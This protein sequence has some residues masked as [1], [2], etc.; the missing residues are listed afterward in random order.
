MVSL[1][2]KTLTAPVRLPRAPMAVQPSP[3]APDSGANDEDT[4]RRH[5]PKKNLSGYTRSGGKQGLLSSTS[6]TTPKFNQHSG[7]EGTTVYTKDGDRVVIGEPEGEIL[8][9]RV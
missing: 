1:D 6:H 4:R 5:P 3:S 2:G 7:P 9:V 8:D